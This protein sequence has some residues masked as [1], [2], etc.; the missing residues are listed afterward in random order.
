MTSNQVGRAARAAIPIGNLPSRTHKREFSGSECRRASQ[1]VTW[2]VVSGPGRPYRSRMNAPQPPPPL[3][4]SFV[5]CAAGVLGILAWFGSFEISVTQAWVGLL[6]VVV[7]LGLMLRAVGRQLASK[8]AIDAAAHDLQAELDRAR[9]EQDQLTND[10]ATLR[11]YSNRLLEDNELS[12]VLLTSTQ[13]FS[14]LLPGC[15]GSIYPLTDGEG[16][17][18]ESVLWGIHSCNSA[19]QTSAENC[20]AMHRRRIHLGD[21]HIPD[22][23][24]AHVEPVEGQEFSTACIPLQTPNQTHGWLYLSAPNEDFLKLSMAQMAAEYLAVRL[25]TLKL[26][27]HLRDQTVRDPLT[28]L[29]NR[30]YLTESLGREMGRSARRSLHLAVLAFDIDNFKRF[31]DDYGHGAGDAVL[32]AFSRLLQSASRGEDI[33]CRMGGEEFV[34][35]M[36]EMEL[37]VATRRAEELLAAVPLMTVMHDGQRLPPVTTSIGVAVFPE[38]GR[39]PDD[40]LTR[41]DQALYRAKGEGRNR[42]AIAHPMAPAA[43]G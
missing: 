11:G 32:V 16:L 2:I 15:A 5:A 26:Q 42:L 27:D 24:C 23:L 22:S 33:A 20:W 1:L 12:Q 39:R 35:I 41:A 21:S 30:R 14:M 8:A 25:A 43:A 10:L 29:F 19:P 4:R 37:S 17:A 40:L 28:G 6:S 7:L 13:M 9:K 3:P 38:H 18:E 36:P 34:L 31:N